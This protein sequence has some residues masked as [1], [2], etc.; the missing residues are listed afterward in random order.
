MEKRRMLKLL[1]LS[2][3][4]AGHQLGLTHPDFRRRFPKSTYGERIA[5][6]N[7]LYWKWFATNVK[8]FQPYTH[9]VINGDAVDG[10]GVRTGGV[11][12]ITTDREVQTNMIKTI[13]DWLGIP[14]VYLTYGTSSHTGQAEDWERVLASKLDATIEDELNL[15]LN[16]TI[17]NFRHHVTGSNVVYGRQS[18]VAKAWFNHLLNS[19]AGYVD[20]A[21]V[22]VRS[23]VHYFSE[24][25]GAYPH[26]W[27]A[28]TTPA[29]MGY[30]PKYA[31]KLSGGVDFGFLVF[32]IKPDGSWSCKDVI[33]QKKPSLL[34]VK[35]YELK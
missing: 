25:G 21:D 30:G 22:L 23:H 26:R 31:R 19:L 9:L 15:N 14:E 13:V 34:K 8:R 35:S 24:V 11:E 7:A 32:T 20:K 10:D 4:H 28:Y 18:G 2:D 5:S 12:Q 17:F 1:V 27:K 29:L 3:T 16:N 33:M 6:Q